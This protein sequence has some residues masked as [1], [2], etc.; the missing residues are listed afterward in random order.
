MNMRPILATLCCALSIASYAQDAPPAPVAPSAPTLPP[1]PVAPVKPP[2]VPDRERTIY[3]PYDEL[4]KIFTDGG[5][6]VFLPY[7]EF[8]ELWNE[9]NLKRTKEDETKPPQDGIVSK[10]EYIARI[11]GET[12]VMDAVVTVESFKKGWLTVPLAKG[13]TLPGIAQAETGNAVLQAKADG[14]DVLLPDKGRYDLKFK[15]YTPVKRT[16]GKQ[17]VTLALPQA[18]VSRFTATVPQSG[19]EFKVEPAAAFTTRLTGADTE[20]SFFF[21][22]GGRFEV[23]WSR[24]E[25]ATPLTP[26]VLASS[27]VSAEVRS[28][29][30]ATKAVF[31]FRI[32]RAPVPGFSFLIPAG[33]ELLSV[34]GDDVKDFKLE[35]AGAQQKL[36]VTPNAPVREKWNVTLAL[37]AP[38]P[39]LPAE[40]AVPEI[41]VEGATQDRGEVSI[42]AESQLDVM[43]KPAEGLVQQ[44]QTAAPAQGLS[45]VGGYRFLKHPARLSLA[46]AEAKPQVDVGSSTTL[47][48]RREI[49]LVRSVFAYNVRRVGIFEARV[50]LPAGWSAWEVIGQPSDTWTVEKAGAAEVM[51]LKLPKQ[52]LGTFNFTLRGQ[53][54]RTSATEDASVP[55]FAPQNVAMH[56]GKIGVRVHS[57]LEVTTKDKGELR[58]DDVT[59]FQEMTARKGQFTAPTEFDPPQIPQSAAPS[60]EESRMELTL[61]FRHRDAVKT[62]ATLAFKAREPQVNVEVLTLVEAKEQS[63]RHTWTLAFDVAYAGTDRFVLA[64]PKTVA[65]DIRFVDTSVKEILKDYKPT[66]AVTKALT[67]AANYALWEVVLRSE[68][69]GAFSL[70][71][72]LEKPLPAD[73]AAKLE[74]LPVHVPG[75][76]QEIGQVAVVKEDALEIRDYQP[77]NLEEIDPTEL[78]SGL[79]RSGVFLAFKSRTPAV[80]LALDVTR[81]AYIPV[82]QAVVTHAVMTAAVASDRAQTIEMIYWVR[83]NAQQFLTVKLPKGARLVSDVFVDGATQQP[84]KREGSE[85]LL[86]RLPGGN[87]SGERSVPVRFVYEIPSAK[88]GERMGIMGGFTVEP[89]QLT[90]V[91]VVL[92]SHAQLF[93]PERNDYTSFGGPM[94]QSLADRGWGRLRRLFDPLLPSFGP[95][96]AAPMEQWKPAPPIPDNQKASFDFK[97][98]EQGQSVKLH[99]L[100]PPAAVD[101]SFRSRKLSWSL[102]GLAFLAV[103]IGGISW[104]RQPLPRKV[105]AAAVIGGVALIGTGLLG[106]VNGVIAQAVMLGVLAVVALWIAFTLPAIWRAVKGV[107]LLSRIFG[108]AMLAQFMVL[109]LAILAGAR[110]LQPVLVVLLVLTALAW[111]VTVFVSAFREGRKLPSAPVTASA[112]GSRPEAPRPA[113]PPVNPPPAAPPPSA[114]AT[115]GDI[116]F[117]KIDG[118]DEPKTK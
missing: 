95:Q 116:E 15:I 101:V 31:D 42:A 6:G 29:S 4:E 46:V 45:A 87:G 3:V 83:N 70:T 71:L 84:M 112:T 53:R 103:V 102:E 58:L 67:D 96:L 118:G 76:F 80:K 30:L 41:I 18:A 94:E 91:A 74:L 36:T 49:A 21:G 28:G 50:A 115:G 66:E 44:T 68:R 88:A 64:V 7:K 60:S 98:P 9:L 79:A 108:P 26:L 86:V 62:S 39:K 90:D 43:P 25:A 51:V 104:L 35:A 78:R 37:E 11:E 32:L 54:Q 55:A 16:G 14:Y 107:S 85:D 1:P 82:P 114:P 24:P 52:T 97:L 23:S 5:K 111:A 81:N 17:T 113:A 61:A 59:A 13:G 40:A 33:Q 106:A 110:S 109:V 22:S 38:L 100:G 117:P 99:R 65:D 57:S 48:V 72:S 8:L 2:P 47:D 27:Q 63:L 56:D 75:A 19:W 93:L 92:E 10:A 77:E 73:K 34:T 20:L 69:I 105:L 89:P 12:L